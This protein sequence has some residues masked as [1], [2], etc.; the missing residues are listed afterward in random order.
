MITIANIEVTPNAERATIEEI[1]QAYGRGDATMDMAGLMLGLGAV[2]VLITVV[3]A[4]QRWKRREFQI[5]TRF[6]F[7]LA[8]WDIGLNWQQTCLLARIARRSQLSSP[9]TL[10][11][12]PQ[13]L[14]HFAKTAGNPADLSAARVL[15]DRLFDSPS[16]LREAAPL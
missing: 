10:L 6:L 2:M 3:A 7:A 13:T 8:A 5:P 15:A 1:S 12:C 14:L 9:M 4:W 16:G 11:V